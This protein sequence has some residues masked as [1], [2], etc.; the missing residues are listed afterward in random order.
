[1]SNDISYCTYFFLESMENQREVSEKARQE[2][3]AEDVE[4][5]D[6]SNGI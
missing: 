4:K 1:M 6:V 2:E 3:R 5:Q